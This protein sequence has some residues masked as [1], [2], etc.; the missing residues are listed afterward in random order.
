MP[1]RAQKSGCQTRRLP[2][3]KKTDR[4]TSAAHLNV[5]VRVGADLE[6]YPKR[7]SAQFERI[8][9]EMFEVAAVGIRHLVQRRAVDDDERRIDPALVRVAQL[10]PH[11]SGAWRLLAL[12]CELQRAGE[13]GR[14]KLRHCRRES[15][16]D[17]LEELPH[18]LSLAR[19]H[20]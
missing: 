12:H 1:A 20:E 5:C 3:S 11:Q 15:Q 4:T 18:T 19:G 7:G 2:R 10:R 6:L 14:G 9:E 16:I 8:A 17:R 13:S